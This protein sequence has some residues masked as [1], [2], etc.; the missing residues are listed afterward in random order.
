M[1]LELSIMMGNVMNVLPTAYNVQMKIPVLYVQEIKF[2][3]KGLANHAKLD[4]SI[5]MNSAKAANKIVSFVLM[6]P[7]VRNALKER[8]SLEVCANSA[9]PVPIFPTNNV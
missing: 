9:H 4:F 8:F 7:L 6:N 2:L 5:R 3:L 1:P